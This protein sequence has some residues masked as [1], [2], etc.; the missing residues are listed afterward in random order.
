MSISI[1]LVVALLRY[2][3]TF[4]LSSAPLCLYFDSGMLFFMLSAYYQT[5][6]LFF[7]CRREH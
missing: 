2:F 6:R 7:G 3:F 1:C 5:R 4:E